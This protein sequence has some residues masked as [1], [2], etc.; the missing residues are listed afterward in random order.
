MQ[1]ALLNSQLKVFNSQLA[2]RNLHCPINFDDGIK[3]HLHGIKACIH[4]NSW[5]QKSVFI[6]IMP[7][8]RNMSNFDVR[9]SCSVRKLDF[10]LMLWQDK[11]LSICFAIDPFTKLLNKKKIS[12]SSELL[13]NNSLEVSCKADQITSAQRSGFY[14]TWSKI[15]KIDFFWRGSRN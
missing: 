1:L 8:V 14:R 10:S 13:S 15:S 11:N 2:T 6:F 5:V 12:S 3:F 9:V 7:C 4:E